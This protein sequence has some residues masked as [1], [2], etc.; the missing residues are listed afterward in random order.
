MFYNAIEGGNKVLANTNLISFH[1]KQRKQYTRLFNTVH[2]GDNSIFVEAGLDWTQ[3]DRIA[4][5]PS[6][7]DGSASDYAI[8]Q[9]YN[10]STG[11]TTL[12]R[13]LSYYHWG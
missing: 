5:A 9:A 8:V 13:S 1:G 2:P 12:D 6:T 10:A 3:G 4:L 7:M 11:N